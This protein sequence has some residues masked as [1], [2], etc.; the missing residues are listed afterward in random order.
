MSVIPVNLAT[1]DELSEAVLRRLLDHAARGYVV[2][3]AY[4]RAGFGYLR[5]TIIGWNRAARGIPFIVLTDLDS[6]LCPAALISDWL[7][8]PKHPNLILRVAVREVEAW[9][10]A[11]TLNLAN[12]LGVPERIVPLDS[13]AL[14]DAK[15]SLVELASRSRSTDVRARIAPRRGST[16]KQG[17]DYNASLAKFVQ[18]QW[19]VEAA[20]SR[21]LS[22]SRT[23]A[24]LGTF[25]PAWRRGN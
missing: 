15:G 10:L 9:L 14:R 4:G 23:V 22:L 3:S 20:R 17:P 1:E 18:T 11:D 13:D 12:Y 8:E 25:T 19:D 16:A 6:Y 21:S 2:G 7:T 24:K 5:N